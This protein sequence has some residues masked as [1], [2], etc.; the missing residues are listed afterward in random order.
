MLGWEHA[1]AIS[2]HL[3]KNIN[4]RESSWRAVYS[5]RFDGYTIVDAR[6][7]TAVTW[8]WGCVS[9]M[10]IWEGRASLFPPFEIL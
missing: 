10:F 8:H 5:S 4:A 1:S 9:H 6:Y 2:H 7:G 3:V